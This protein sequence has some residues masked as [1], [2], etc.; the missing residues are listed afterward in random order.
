MP[1]Y[2]KAKKYLY[3]AVIVT[4]ALYGEETRS[5]RNEERRTVNVPQMK[6]LRNFCMSD[7]NGLSYE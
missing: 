2:I 3:D 5:M 4:T 7:T 1:V 6:C